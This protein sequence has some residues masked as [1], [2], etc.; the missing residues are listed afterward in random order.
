MGDSR[1]AGIAGAVRCLPRP[2]SR[3]LRL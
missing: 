1:K 2:V 3:H